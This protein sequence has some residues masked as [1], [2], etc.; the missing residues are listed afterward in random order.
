MTPFFLRWMRR[1]LPRDTVVATAV[2]LD[3]VLE[4]AYLWSWWRFGQP[5]EDIFAYFRLAIQ[6][7]SAG[8]YGVYRIA[9]FHPAND[10]DYRQWL[11]TT[12]WTSRQPLPMGPVHIVPQDVIVLLGSMALARV[13]D[14]RLLAIPVAFLAGYN[15][16]LA[17]L[18][19]ATGQKLFA[20]LIAVGFGG[21]ILRILNP[22][23]ALA[24]AGATTIVGAFA[25]RQSLRQFPWEIPWYLNGA[26]WKQKIEDFK[27]HRTG[28]P[29]DVL[30]PQPLRTW[31][32]LSDGLGA[33]AIIAWWFAAVF[34]QLPRPVMLVLIQFAVFAYIAS[35]AR[36]ANVYTKNHKPPISFWGRI[37]T[38]RPW[39]VG[40]D[41]ILIA[42]VIAT[43][44]FVG[45]IAFGVATLADGVP[46]QGRWPEWM[47]YV[48]VPLGVGAFA[49]T[50][51]LGG[52]PIE[53]WRLRGRHRIVFDQTGKPTGLGQA[54]KDKEFVQTA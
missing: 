6:V 51:L 7:V 42:P 33:S 38:R 14:V 9:T 10:Q 54:T 2:M 52:P 37:A 31:I 48:G 47:G 34:V 1:V 40:Y 19:W 15:L 45:T 22:P 43:T 21:V 46:W 8:S 29:F 32:E 18:T 20:Y 39:Q 30:A 25:L 24:C 35:I 3:M 17:I 11:M 28:W 23:E 12:P 5:D 13:Y 41:E 49:L 26:D 27:E 50:M 16:A 44:I 4:A 36:Y 53:T